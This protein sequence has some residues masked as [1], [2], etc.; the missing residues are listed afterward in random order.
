ME[1]YGLLM[2]KSKNDNKQERPSR[3]QK[4]VKKGP[5]EYFI[6]RPNPI[7]AILRMDVPLIRKS[8]VSAF[9]RGH[10]GLL[11]LEEI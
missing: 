9:L 5:E 6:S 3:Q 4:S 1:M 8:S 2:P 11:L 7:S 10:L